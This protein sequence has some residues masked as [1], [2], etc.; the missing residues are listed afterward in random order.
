MGDRRA[1]AAA[2]ALAVVMGVYVSYG[3]A[4]FLL[5]MALAMAGLA[6]LATRRPVLAAG[7]FAARADGKTNFL[8]DT[9]AGRL[10]NKLQKQLEKAGVNHIDYLILTHAHFDHAAMQ[11]ML[12]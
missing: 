8:I 9:S 2:I 4:P 6:L 12:S 3:Q 10:W 7:P 5:A 11:K 1:R